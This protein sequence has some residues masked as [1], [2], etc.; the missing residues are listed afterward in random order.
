MSRRG[1]TSWYGRSWGECMFEWPLASPPAWAVRPLKE[2]TEKIGSGAT[3]RG[4]REVYL[5]RGTS[6][7]RSQNVLD[8]R[9]AMSGLVFIDDEAASSLAGVE[10]REGDVLLNITGDSIARCSVVDPELLPARVN[11]HV[12]IIRA[13]GEINPLFLQKFLVQPEYKSFMLSLSSGATRNALTKGQ[14]ERFP[15]PV[16]PLWEQS[17]LVRVLGALDG[18]IAVNERIR[19]AALSLARACYEAA[20]TTCEPERIGDLAALFDGPHA[21]PQKTESGPW[22]LS[23]SSLKNGYL[24]L[25]ESAHLSEGDFP[26]WTRRVQPQA[27]DVLFSYE[28]RLGDAA[29]MPSGVRSSLGRRMGLLRSKSESVSGALLL[30]AY[31]SAGFQEEIKRRTIH[32]A[33]V[34]RLPLKEMP[35]WHIP[36]P[37]EGERE[38]LSVKLDLLHSRVTQTANESRALAA[39]RDNLLPHLMSGKLRVRD[40]EKIVEDAV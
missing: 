8:N 25:A 16:P 3:P 32:G 38:R 23:I 7:I 21:T 36:L 26:R 27:G 12:A 24:D 35:G 34:D 2:L 1:W 6:F 31:L 33:T 40:A 10:V 29:L 18:K 28:T 11:Q 9:T 4:G 5:P 19:D 39:L 13:T 15:I 20:S 22:F 14:I 30:H 37:A 17:A